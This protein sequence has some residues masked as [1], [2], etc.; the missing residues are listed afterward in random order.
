MGIGLCEFFAFEKTGFTGRT[1][2]RTA[3]SETRR[4]PRLGMK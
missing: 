1:K 2:N 4:S 3:I